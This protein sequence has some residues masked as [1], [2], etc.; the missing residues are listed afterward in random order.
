[1]KFSETI[2]VIFNWSM[3]FWDV[4]QPAAQFRIYS[5]YCSYCNMSTIIATIIVTSYLIQYRIA[6][7]IVTSYLMQYRI[8]TI[9]VTSYLM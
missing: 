1:M 2:L 3:R 7:I 9:I 8:A 4:N 5:S 6:T